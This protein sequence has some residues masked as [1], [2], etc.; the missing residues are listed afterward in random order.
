MV[1]LIWM[2]VIGCH[3]S[4]AE[5]SSTTNSASDADCR[6][7]PAN[8]ECTEGAVYDFCI[9]GAG[10]GGLQA[11]YFMQRLD[12]NYVVLE[13]GPAPGTFFTRYP[14]HR[15]LLSVN[16][17][18][19]GGEASIGGRNKE[20][21]LDYHLRFD[22]N[23]LLT[24]T[25]IAELDAPLLDAPSFTFRNY[26]EAYYPHAD[27]LVRYLDDFAKRH[28][29][30]VMY[31]TR[32]TAVYER[33]ERGE[34]EV[35]EEERGEEEEEE[36]SGAAAED[37][38][39]ETSHING[40]R[41]TRSDD[42]RAAAAAAR[43][44]AQDNDR[45]GDDN[46]MD[47]QP[48]GCLERPPPRFRLVTTTSPHRPNTHSH[49]GC[50]V[51]LLATGLPISRKVVAIEGGEHIEDCG[52]APTNA[53]HFQNQRVF[54][55]GAGNSALELAQATESHTALMHIASR[56]PFRF[57][58]QSRYEGDPRS[59]LGGIL[60][61]YQ[62]KSN[63][64]LLTFTSFDARRPRDRRRAPVAADDLVAR[65]GRPV[66]I[67]RDE[68]SGLLYPVVEKR[69]SVKDPALAVPGAVER[70][71][72]EPILPQLGIRKVVAMREAAH[73]PERRGYHRIVACVGFVWDDAPFAP[74]GNAS[75]VT[76]L[77]AEEFISAVPTGSAWRRVAIAR[78]ETDTYPE[79]TSAF[80]SVSTPHLYVAGALMHFRDHKR[81]AGGF[82]HGFR[83][84]VRT[85]VR[86]LH[87]RYQPTR[88]R[89]EADAAGSPSYHERYQR[90]R[91]QNVVVA[92]GSSGGLTGGYPSTLLPDATA[93]EDKVMQRLSSSSSL[94]QMHNVLSD[95][96]VKEGS[97]VEEGSTHRFRYYEDLPLDQITSRSPP[98]IAAVARW[99]RK[100]AVP[101]VTVSLE[102]A[103][104]AQGVGVLH[105]QGQPESFF[106]QSERLLWDPS[107]AASDPDVRAASSRR[108][109]ARPPWW[110]P[111]LQKVSDLRIMMRDTNYSA[112]GRR[113][114]AD[115]LHMLH[116]LSG[117]ADDVVVGAAQRQR[118]LA[119]STSGLHPVLRRWRFLDSNQKEYSP[120]S[121]EDEVSL[122]FLTTG[123]HDHQVKRFVAKLFDRK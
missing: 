76:G 118:L 74:R 60:D 83:Y 53:T 66:R 98:S 62:L 1:L 2:V 92:M 77:A 123:S 104:E 99:L 108:E 90:T 111:P 68:G 19:I 18:H 36:A 6:L 102:Y 44:T 8:A 52:D 14:R 100:Q 85:L 26:S 11:A 70:L 82:I 112:F 55:F 97:A 43:T 80:E 46:E 34:E 65:I 20:A 9:I 72:T 84:L 42:R 40:G 116:R 119:S 117:T 27:D 54:I 88:Q 5:I 32:V 12:M 57:A 95:V 31:N 78:D 47:R 58:F 39:Q 121:Q 10:P 113:P 109:E 79:V 16:K 35:E 91:K 28:E 59:H 110:L 96:I 15:Q 45:G 71:L 101:F 3:C 67:F 87:E 7:S 105:S 30:N 13:S 107:N 89:V 64:A 25:G 48:D 93:V 38:E 114:R 86:Q 61:R 33:E 41:R 63:D 115:D 50:S 22:W 69:Y 49:V 122:H 75:V 4:A 56:R 24:S 73:V 106:E 29:L 120:P 37:D 21:A 94:F 23:S 81:S 103:R 51:V 17:V